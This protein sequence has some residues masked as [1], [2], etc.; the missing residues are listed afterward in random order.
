MNWSSL[1]RKARKHCYVVPI[2]LIVYFNRPFPKFSE[3]Q[4]I[5]LYSDEALRPVRRISV[6]SSPRLSNFS[7]LDSINLDFEN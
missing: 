2:G 7:D 3:S 5:C 1:I 6:I 4:G